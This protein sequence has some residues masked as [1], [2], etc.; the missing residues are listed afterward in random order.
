MQLRALEFG[1]PD[2]EAKLAETFRGG[3]AITVVRN[4][5]SPMHLAVVAQQHG[6]PYNYLSMLAN[7]LSI[8]QKTQP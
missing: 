5:Q 1:T 6:E 7:F 2:E 4:L 3:N 8:L